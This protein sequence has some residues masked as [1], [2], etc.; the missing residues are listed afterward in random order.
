MFIFVSI[1]SMVFVFSYFYFFIYIFYLI[2]FLDR[3]VFIICCF[4]VFLF[5]II[6]GV[7]VVGNVWGSL[8][9]IDLVYGGVENFVDVLNRI[10][11][12]I[13]E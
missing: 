7:Y 5:F 3:F 12:N 10:F 1:S 4:F 8:N 13:M 6:M 11:W 2:E 9:V